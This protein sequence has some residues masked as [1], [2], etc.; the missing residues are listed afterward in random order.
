LSDLFS[1][2]TSVETLAR[3]FERAAGNRA[4]PGPDGVTLLEF[5][6]ELDEQLR[7]LSD[8]LRAGVYC[9]Q[10]GQRIALERP[11]GRQRRVVRLNVRDRVVH[12]AL[13]L[14]LSLYLDDELHDFAWAYRKGRSGKR[15][16]DALEARLRSTERGWIFRGD[17]ED[18]FDRIP[19][20]LLT[21]TL[22]QASGEPSLVELLEKLLQAG[23]FTGD[24]VIDEATGAPQGSALSPFLANLVMAPFD[25]ALAEA[26]LFMVRYGDDLCIPT[27]SCREATQAE[28]RVRQE[29]AK[30]GLVLA[31][32][33]VIV[34]N[35]REGFDYL[36]FRIDEQGRRP[37][38][39]A[40]RGLQAKLQALVDAGRPDSDEERDALLRGWLAYYG[41]FDQ[42][43]PPQ[44]QARAEELE[45][46]WVQ[47]RQDEALEAPSTEDEPA[48]EEPEPP[49]DSWS[50]ERLDAEAERLAQQGR[51][52]DAERARAEQAE[53][54]RAGVEPARRAGE[55]E[56]RAPA[57]V[58]SPRPRARTRLPVFAACPRAQQLYDGCSMLGAMVDRAL[59]GQGLV[60]S[61][62]F[63]ITDLMG[64]IG[65]E[66][67]RA[68]DGVLRH[69]VD[70]KPGM[71]RRLLSRLFPMPTSCA[72]IR[73]RMPELAEQV[74]CDCRFRLEGGV[75]PTPL[76]HVLGAT[77]IPGLEGRVQK[78]AL[79]RSAAKA[80]V[81]A[82]N[83][84]HK[85][86]G[87][88]AAALCT[89][90]ADVRRQGRLL[91]QEQ[92]RIEEQ[93]GSLL[94]EAGGA[95]LETPAGALRRVVCE[96]GRVRF[97][98]EV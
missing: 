2:A 11:D 95:T 59:S 45:A 4:G 64:R 71:A 12:H 28:A 30:L 54:A 85:D 27:A 67:E 17:I 36:G 89:R 79:K 98:L 22:D 73:Q 75:Y 70:H 14:T 94:D 60:A 43:L 50:V 10:P 82:M 37:G 13:A 5:S 61:E 40:R 39:R 9:P 84:G 15:A 35:L 58:D 56:L 24:A 90:L 88:R 83:A 16:L 91:Q 18:F 20:P 26:G 6:R 62:R 86:L 44:V 96:D 46:A 65:D 87:D 63:L 29:L 92:A 33:K 53:A 3:G 25:R 66:A 57:A 31:E 41:P 55:V 80:V 1:L 21:S 48:A 8:G 38:E 72:R 68:V 42:P 52:D 19:H 7:A 34:A 32:S 51:F 49:P 93:L 76:L 74:G 81:E 47:R 77:E 97:I 23:Q 78:A 69:L